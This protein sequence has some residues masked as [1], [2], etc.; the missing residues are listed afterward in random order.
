M[1]NVM[2]VDDSDAIRMVLKDIL[3]IGQHKLVAELAS[4][5]D[6]LEEYAKTKPDIVLLDMAMPKKDGLTALKE[7]IAYDPKAKVIMI[8]ASDNQETVRECI[9]TG[10]S[11]YVLKPFNFQEVLKI[12]NRVVKS[13]SR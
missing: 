9:K 5:I 4:G 12:I 6:V 3:V 10:A 7:I 1:V 2:V 11:T 8:S 13:Q